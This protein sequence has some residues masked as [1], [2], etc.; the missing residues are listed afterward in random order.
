LFLLCLPDGPENAAWLDNDERDWLRA[1]VAKDDTAAGTVHRGSEVAYAL[2]QVRV[3]VLG[4]FLMCLY[5]GNY[6]YI[7]SAP[8]MIQRVTGFSATGV[9]FVV[10]EFWAHSPCC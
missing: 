5:I 8:S 6:G 9:G 7:F 4:L 1:A 2:R 10:P 3:W